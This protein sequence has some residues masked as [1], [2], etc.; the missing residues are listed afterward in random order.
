MSGFHPEI[1]V[2][3]GRGVV[4][5]VP[6][7]IAK[8][9][10][11]RYQCTVFSEL[12]NMYTHPLSLFLFLSSPFLLSFL[13]GAGGWWGKLGAL[14]GKVPPPPPPLDETLNVLLLEF[15]WPCDQL[16]DY[17]LDHD[18][19]FQPSSSAPEPLSAA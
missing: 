10:W 7:S 1:L 16:C 4:N 3:G 17:C 14:E 13:G 19:V 6:L 8:S 9:G 12:A 18:N 5:Y 2:W 11:Q 15:M